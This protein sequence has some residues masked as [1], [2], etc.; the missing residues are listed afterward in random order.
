MLQL[1]SSISSSSHN[2]V[3]NSNGSSEKILKR[4][5]DE[6]C[7]YQWVFSD[8]NPLSIATHPNL[9]EIATFKKQYKI[10][11]TLVIHSN[12]TGSYNGWQSIFEIRKDIV[13]RHP[14]LF[15]NLHDMVSKAKETILK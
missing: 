11:F 12:Y 10:S 15:L 2:R 4:S 8:F 1:V 9:L 6:K 13:S 5:E 14:A 7:S 3:P